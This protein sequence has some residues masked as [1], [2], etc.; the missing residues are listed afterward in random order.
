MNMREFSKKNRMKSDFATTHVHC[1]L[2]MNKFN[3]TLMKKIFSIVMMTG[4]I[5]VFSGCDDWLDLKPEGEVVLEDFWQD[6]SHVMQVLA[7]C[8]QSL[9]EGGAMERMLMWGEVRSDNIMPGNLPNDH[10]AATDMLRMMNFDIIPNNRYAQWGPFYTT[11]NYCNTFLHFAP[12]VVRRDENFTENRLRSLTAEVLTI[13]ALSYFYL[14]RAFR[15]VPWIEQ[16]SIDDDQDYRVPKSPEDEILDKLEE[17]LRYA[18]IYARETFETNRHT[19]GRVTRN[20]IRALLVDIYLWREKYEESVAMADAIINDSQFSLVSGEALL[21]QVF[22][23]GNSTESIF[24]LQFDTDNRFNQV[25]YNFYGGSG[26]TIGHWQLNYNLVSPT[27]T[28]RIFNRPNSGNVIESV[29]D[30]RQKDF[31][32]T[33]VDMVFPFKYVGLRTESAAGVSSYFY[34][35]TTANWIFYRLSDIKLMKAEALIQMGEAHYAEAMDL[36]NTVYL[37][38]NFDEFQ[39]PLLL[40]HYNSRLELEGL[41]YRERQRELM[42]EGKRYFDLLRIARREN[43]PGSLLNVVAR[44]V[45]SLPTDKLSSMDALYLPIHISELR[46]NRALEQNPYYLLSDQ[47]I[48]W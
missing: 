39:Q 38:S 35:S 43:N 26:N 42:F 15:D 10:G 31:A 11:I 12:E 4:L 8:Y 45:T 13:R 34:R 20:A 40:D 30:I 36:I 3:Y 19:K 27:N 2:P 16:P 14:V 18:L 7:A 17:D 5:F 25:I 9:T 1:I 32:R 46:N 37:R 24:E 47:S 44:K 6:E 23:S 29:D 22:Y 41:L 21:Q 28:F 48:N 33:I